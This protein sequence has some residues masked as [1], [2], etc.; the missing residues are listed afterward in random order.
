M[1]VLGIDPGLDGAFVVTDGKRL[2]ST[3]MPITVHGKDKA[4]YFGGVYELLMRI[5]KAHGVIHVFLERAIPFALGAKSAFSYGRG[6]EAIV[7]AIELAGL[8]CTLIEPGK[9]TKEM[10]EGISSDLKPK[11]KSVI[12]VKRLYPHMVGMLPTKPKG[13]LREGP[14]DALLIAGYGLRSLSGQVTRKRRMN[15]ISEPEDF[16]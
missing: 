15:P 4:V 6:F 1:K 13:G 14:V 16:Y 9:W 3:S 11:V 12:A 10:H 2:T 7:I 8:P 5:Q